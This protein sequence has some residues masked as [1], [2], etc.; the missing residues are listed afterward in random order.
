MSITSD[1][2][3]VWDG[4]NKQQSNNKIVGGVTDVKLYVYIGYSNFWGCL[5]R[6]VSFNFNVLFQNKTN[7]IWVE[8]TTD[9]VFCDLKSSMSLYQ[10]STEFVWIY[11]SQ[12]GAVFVLNSLWPCDAVWRY[13][14]GSI[15]AHRMDWCSTAPIHCLNQCR[16]IVN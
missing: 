6:R 5:K 8:R 4:Y 15:S 9:S 2:R 12:Q 3:S 14:S 1:V 7:G 13:R 11:F 16:L 10:T